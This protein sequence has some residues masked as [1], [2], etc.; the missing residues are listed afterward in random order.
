ME[1]MRT[2]DRILVGKSEGRFLSRVLKMVTVFK[3]V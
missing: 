1:E 3:G 2:T